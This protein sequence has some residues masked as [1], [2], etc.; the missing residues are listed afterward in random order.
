MPFMS[1]RR[2]EILFVLVLVII[3]F[4]A[5]TTPRFLD[6]GIGGS[7]TQGGMRTYAPVSVAGII[8]VACAGTLPGNYT[9]NTTLRI[10]VIAPSSFP[11]RSDGNLTVVVAIHNELPYTQTINW[12]WTYSPFEGNSVGPSGQQWLQ[13]EQPAGG[14]PVSISANQTVYLTTLLGTSPAAS[15]QTASIYLGVPYP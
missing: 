3:I 2:V 14:P 5:I 8:V 9:P 13:T 11:S 6:Q 10:T 4:I 12:I 15:G 7:G 1:R